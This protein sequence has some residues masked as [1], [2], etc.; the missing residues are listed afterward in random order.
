MQA[1]RVKTLIAADRIA[2]QEKGDRMTQLAESIKWRLN[3]WDE[4]QHAEYVETM[5]RG[6]MEYFRVHADHR[7]LI[8]SNRRR[9]P[10]IYK[11]EYYD[12]TFYPQLQE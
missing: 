6:W 10:H 7:D 3:Q 2:E 1:Y 12:E 11:E 9:F 8:K 4:K 5:L